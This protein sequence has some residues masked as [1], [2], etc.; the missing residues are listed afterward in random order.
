MQIGPAS[1]IPHRGTNAHQLLQDLVK[2]TEDRPCMQDPE[3]W[4]STNS[5]DIRQAKKWCGT[6]PLIEKCGAYAIEAHEHGGVWGG[7]D[8][9]ERNL[10]RRRMTQNQRRRA[11]SAARAAG[12]LEEVA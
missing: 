10:A 5:Y 1:L 11:K 2:S 6:C 8:D 4:W 12:E 7:M 3:M 9:N